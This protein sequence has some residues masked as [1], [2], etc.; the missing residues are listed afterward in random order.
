M[1]HL[2]VSLEHVEPR[3]TLEALLD[4]FVIGFASSDYL[5]QRRAVELG[6]GAM[7]LAESEGTADPWRPLVKIET[8]LPLPARGEMHV[9]CARS[10]RYV[11]RVRVVA[12]AI[13]ERPS[14]IPGI[15]VA[16]GA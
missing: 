11:A 8:R 16:S 10:M 5:A 2:G 14:E 4:P 15:E 6:L 1:D 13:T 12:E 9:V 3:P 7:I